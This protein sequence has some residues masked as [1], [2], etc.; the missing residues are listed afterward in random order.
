L[1][2]I[3]KRA[4]MT[5]KFGTRSQIL[6][7]ACIGTIIMCALDL[8]REK[9][10]RL[11]EY[12]KIMGLSESAY[13]TGTL[14]TVLAGVLFGILFVAV[15]C[16]A[17]VFKHKGLEAVGLYVVYCISSVTFGFLVSTIAKTTQVGT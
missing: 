6:Q 2:F 10:Q 13:W 15:I 14:I 11:K 12:L 16:V 4:L 1:H 3:I 8:V 5:T 7:M 9:Q 17:I